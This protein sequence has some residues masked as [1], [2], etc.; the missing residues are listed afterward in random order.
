[1]ENNYDE[2]LPPAYL[3]NQNP[4]AYCSNYYSNSINMPER[5]NKL[6]AVQRLQ[7]SKISFKMPLKHVEREKEY[8]IS[9][10]IESQKKNLIMKGLKILGI[11]YHDNPEK[12]FEENMENEEILDI[13]IG[14]KKLN[15]VFH[16]RRL[17]SKVFMALTNKIN[18]DVEYNLSLKHG[19]EIDNLKDAL[20]Y[21]KLKDLYE[22]KE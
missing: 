18:E 8:L 22:N 20:V 6:N 12:L 14:L 17:R 9:Y 4:Y 1:M 21:C 19:L 5:K 3:N 10:A 15:L 13:L 16:Q 2:A 11:E 7:P